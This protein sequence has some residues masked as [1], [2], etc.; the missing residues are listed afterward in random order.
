MVKVL[1]FQLFESQRVVAIDEEPLEIVSTG[2]AFLAA[3]RSGSVHHYSA[4]VECILLHQFHTFNSTILALQY[5]PS[6]DCV[7]TLEKEAPQSAINV[8]RVYYNWRLSPTEEESMPTSSTSPSNPLDSS[9][10]PN[11][12][13]SQL[14]IDFLP[15]PSSITCIT[16]CPS[17]GRIA[18]AT[19][20]SVSI[21]VQHIYHDSSNNNT[22]KVT[23][24]FHMEKVLELDAPN[25]TK[26]ALYEHYLGYTCSDDLEVKVL[27]LNITFEDP[28]ASDNNTASSIPIGSIPSVL[29]TSASTNSSSSNINTGS[30]SNFISLKSS[31]DSVSDVSTSGVDS[32]S[33]TMTIPDEH[34]IELSFDSTGNPTGKFQLASISASQSTLPTPT[35]GTPASGHRRSMS[36]PP[37]GNS[38]GSGGGMGGSRDVGSGGGVGDPRD[39]GNDLFESLGPFT[40]SDHHANVNAE[41][42]YALASSLLLLHRRFSSDDPIHTLSFLPE[43][44]QQTD[45]THP[46]PSTNQENTL[47]F[48]S[49]GSFL[50][51]I[52]AMRMIVSTAR[53]GYIYKLSNPALLATYT[54][55]AESLQCC[56]SSCFLYVL[57]N[58]GLETWT[59]RTSDTYLPKS[60]PGVTTKLRNPQT[61]ETYDVFPPPCLIGL[62]PFISLQRIVVVGD[63]ILL[64]S[65]MNTNPIPSASRATTSAAPIPQQVKRK[66]LTSAS[67]VSATNNNNTGNSPGGGT[68]TATSTTVLRPGPVK[69]EAWSLYVLHLTSLPLLYNEVIST[70]ASYDDSNTNVYYQLVLEGHFLLKS[71]L[72]LPRPSYGTV[73]VGLGGMP[74]A[75][76]GLLKG[77][78]IVDAAVALNMNI[79]AQNNRALLRRSSTLLANFYVKQK[80]YMLAAMQYATSDRA[81]GEVFTL[82]SAQELTFYLDRVLFDPNMVHLLDDDVALA[83]Q[84][85]MHYHVNAPSRLSSVILD[86][87]LSSYTQSLALQL[88]EMRERNNQDAK[89]LFARALLYL[90]QGRVSDAMAVFKN[91]NPYALVQ[92]CIKNPKLL[93]PENIELDQEGVPLLGKMLR[94]TS[95]WEL[96]SI[97]VGLSSHIPIPVAVSMLRGSTADA[98]T[99]Y[100]H[101]DLDVDNLLLK[102][103][104]EHL[105]IDAIQKKNV[106]LLEFEELIVNLGTIYLDDIARHRGVDEPIF[107][108]SIKK[109]ERENEKVVPSPGKATVITEIVEEAEDYSVK[110]RQFHLKAFLNRPQ[111]SQWLDL[112]P[113]FDSHSK[114][115]P[116]DRSSTLRNPYEFDDNSDF[117]YTFLYVKKCQALLLVANQLQSH[118]LAESVEG[119]PRASQAPLERLV[120]A[121]ASPAPPSPSQA[122]TTPPH[123][124]SHISSHTISHPLTFSLQLLALPMANRLR[125]GL[126][127]VVQHFPQIAFDYARQFC[128]NPSQ[129]A[130]LLDE[131]L[132]VPSGN[133]SVPAV[134]EQIVEFLT[135]HVDPEAFLNLLPA[136]GHLMYF[137]PYMEKAFSRHR[138]KALKNNIAQFVTLD[139][140]GHVHSS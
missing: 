33:T 72:A 14:G 121:L 75:E 83:D 110:W 124:A 51:P 64:L 68:Y 109:D 5:A 85:L 131:L 56:A 92:F 10:R 76:T 89:D 79:E 119:S 87:S 2:N 134:Y 54:Y 129:W 24:R 117:D 132:Q 74:N 20:S 102:C 99:M 98:D 135:G 39:M 111:S 60:D 3:T 136:R 25:V 94:I 31:R 45:D 36:L 57:T 17:T 9:F 22:E 62:Q 55:T 61:T 118:N 113:P 69:G 44:A 12:P 38:I 108:S 123:A 137:L 65:K 80:E 100:Y 59:L 127:L 133:T 103:F 93:A 50:P 73:G 66:T 139:L 104:Y 8:A 128:R 71:K 90:D 27:Y 53:Q 30:A 4:G 140:E 6:T 37:S 23:P 21:W 52:I 7:V 63:A 120:Q 70:A 105:V 107:R 58:V 15:I 67:G 138:A 26:L 101:P 29:D 84:I 42:G 95:P 34:F 112:L 32:S 78:M 49:M 47:T 81:I 115:G 16:V 125:E 40:D 116:Y 91:I 97:I 41:A 114:K 82:L 86:S 13:Q 46:A 18:A 88:L 130:T 96:L 1:L 122:T 28:N 35:P 48:G 19:K 77:N 43:Y 106:N 126:Q 11:L